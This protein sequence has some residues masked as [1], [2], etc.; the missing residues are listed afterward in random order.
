MKLRFQNVLC[1]P[2]STFDFGDNGVALLSGP[3]GAGKTSILRGIFFALFGEGNKIQTSGS[4]SCMVE[5]EFDG[6]K[7]VRTKKPNRLVVNEIYEDESGQEM[8]N[9]KFGDTFKISGYIQQNNLNSFILMSPIEKLAFLEKFAFR[10]IDLGKIKGRCKS[11]ISQT[12]EQLISVVSQ[13]NMAISVLETMEIPKEISFPLKCK[14]TEREKAIKNEEIRYKN[15]VILLSREEKEMKKIT[16]EITDLRVLEASLQ[17]RKERLLGLHM[18]QNDC[19]NSISQIEYNGDEELIN[20]E[21][22]L[23]SII[24]SRELSTIEKQLTIDTEILE[25][26]RM[27]EENEMKNLLD[28]YNNSAWKEYDKNELI[29]AID[30]LKTCLS[31]VIKIEELKKERNKN[32][33]CQTEHLHRKAQYE[34]YKAT[35]EKTLVLQCKVLSRQDLYSCPSCSTKLRFEKDELVVSL[36]EDDEKIE[37]DLDSIKQD[38]TR[39]KTSIS[40]L[41]KNIQDDEFILK[42]N[43]HIETE[44]EKIS[45]GYEELSDVKSLKEDLDYL[46]EYQS[47]Q[48]ELEKK[49]KHLEICLKDNKF[50]S[51]YFNCKNNL[52]KLR[53]RRDY[54]LASCPSVPCNTSEEVIREKINSQKQKKIKLEE[55]FN[56]KKEIEQMIDKYTKIIDELSQKHVKEYGLIRDI[57]ELNQKNIESQKRKNDLEIKKKNLENQLEQIQNWKKYQQSLHHYSEWKQKVQDLEHLEKHARNEYASATKLKDKIAEAESIAMVTIIESINTHARVYLDCFFPDNPISVNLQTFK[58]TKKSTKPQINI[59]IEYKG[60]E[61]DLH[62][63]SG[64][65]LSRV[66]LAYTMALA[67][68]FN[69]PLLLLDEC[70]ASLDQELSETVFNA[71]KEN[72]NGKMTLIIAHQVVT[73]SFDKIIYL[74]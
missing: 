19:V 14:S 67:E 48:I 52:E 42:R 41:Q 5:L 6:M 21:T 38:I 39:L 1:Y 23:T 4:T 45:S 50:S 68:M 60:M 26:M 61:A 35:L 51:S 27:E 17:S 47:T 12:N 53:L 58:E 22:I 49:R 73:G 10:D 70:T 34:E 13:L 54:L 32:T 46:L 25:K 56:R 3:S 69:T 66:I 37:S 72:F 63:L 24:A 30:D 11:L 55:L 65:E 2:D 8:I 57:E 28:T 33:V 15:C 43:T 71:I 74:Q 31:D 20:N 40:T 62:M 16:N 64:G 9:K 29:S 44:I 36:A 7:I 59:E 18:E